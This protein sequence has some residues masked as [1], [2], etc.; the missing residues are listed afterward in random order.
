MPNEDGSCRGISSRIGPRGGQ[1]RPRPPR[2]GRPA[3]PTGARWRRPQ[4]S[5]F[6]LDGDVGVLRDDAVTHDTRLERV[7]FMR[8]SGKSSTGTRELIAL[9][10]PT[11]ARPL[12][13]CTASPAR[14]GTAAVGRRQRGVPAVATVVLELGRPTS[15]LGCGDGFGVGWRGP[16]RAAAA[17]AGSRTFGEPPLDLRG[18]HV[19]WAHLARASRSGFTVGAAAGSPR[20]A[21]T[22]TLS[23]VKCRTLLTSWPSSPPHGRSLR[24]GT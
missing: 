19:R 17:E 5:G 15:V 3:A 2:Q 18:R 21:S 16:R 4:P 9:S 14:V 7:Q 13:T 20:S 24:T 12:A 6:P 10:W 8:R 11:A 23:A 1:G 22:R